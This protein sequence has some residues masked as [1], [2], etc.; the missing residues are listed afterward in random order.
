MSTP[1]SLLLSAAAACLLLSPGC[2]KAKKNSTVPVVDDD[3]GAAPSGG[4][5]V[6]G[7]VAPPPAKEM[8]PRVH[9]RAS[10]RELNDVFLLIRQA[11]AA[12][13]P[14]GPI[15]VPAQA[16]AMLLQL[17]YG[18]GMWSNIEW[19]GVMA[20]DARVP[21]EGPAGDLGL[22]GTIAAR[23]ARA[24]L[25]GV[26]EGQRP[27]PLGSGLWELVQED[28]RVLFREQAAA[29][30]FALSAGDLDRAAE[31]VAEGRTGW[32]LQG[33]GD[34]LPPG[35]I[36]PADLVDLPPQSPLM[37]Q[38]QAVSQGLTQLRVDV[39][40][41]SQRDLML[42][43]A[44]L[45]PFEKLGLE[46]LGAPSLR[47]GALEAALPAGAAGVVVMP[48]GSPAALH[49]IL[50]KNVPIEQ[51]PAPFDAMARTVVGGVHTLLDQVQGEVALAVY[52]TPGDKL[53]LLVAASV[54]DPAAAKEALR[55]LQG[56][57]IQALEAF[58]ALAGGKDAAFKI[59]LK[60]DG[61]SF[62]GGKLDLLTL[63]LPKNMASAADEVAYLM[64]PKKELEMVSGAASGVALLAIGGGARDLLG[65]AGK[66][67]L[68]GEGGLALA[69]AAA[70]GCHF[71]VSLDP[72]LMVRA[73][74]LVNREAEGPAAK[75][76]AKLLSELARVPSLGGI[77]VG[78]Q[79]SAGRGSLAFGV[80]R[81]LMM[82]A[83]AAAAQVRG[84][85]DRLTDPIFEG[86]PE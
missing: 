62:S 26:P 4:G 8:G 60:A 47:P 45:A 85:V 48:W 21:L 58:G 25:D 57:G 49:A 82:P 40:L 41:G 66:A 10:A 5:A 37:R 73:A 22:F 34:E 27:Q 38:L 83:P 69:R 51:V 55:G 42:R 44:A 20:V 15:D 54:R 6:I 3:A 65:R 28:Q 81:S 31:L 70:E 78:I 1:R 43:A 9:L 33:V 61:A 11:T 39:D 16:Q 84:L 77:G 64:S 35:L 46:P 7:V 13:M 86:R 52:V 50:D 75:E 17:G 72:I 12:W 23:S 29:L 53:T 67:T 56:A 79:L 36:N 18:P 74:T 30:E 68:A 24:I 63:A 80:P 19:S 32:R 76:Q 59:T 71:C 2:T 14:D